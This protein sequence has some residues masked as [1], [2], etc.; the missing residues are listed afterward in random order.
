[1]HFL[2]RWNCSVPSFDQWQPL[3]SD[4][5]QLNKVKGRFNVISAACLPVRF[6]LLSSGDLVS[7]FL[8]RCAHEAPCVQASMAHEP[9][10][11]D[12]AYT[13]ANE[14]LDEPS[15]EVPRLSHRQRRANWILN[16]RR[17]RFE[18][19]E[20]RRASRAVE[21]GSAIIGSTSRQEQQDQQAEIGDDRDEQAISPVIKSSD[22]QDG[23]CCTL[24]CPKRVGCLTYSICNNDTVHLMSRCSPWLC[25]SICRALAWVTVLKLRKTWNTWN[26]SLQKNNGRPMLHNGLM[27]PKSPSCHHGAEISSLQEAIQGKMFQSGSLTGHLTIFCSRYC[28]HQAILICPGLCIG[29]LLQKHRCRWCKTNKCVRCRRVCPMQFGY[30][31]KADIIIF[32]LHYHLALPTSPGTLIGPHLQIPPKMSTSSLG[33]HS[34][35][36]KCKLLDLIHLTCHHQ[37]YRMS[38][39]Q[40]TETQMHHFGFMMGAFTSIYLNHKRHPAGLIFPGGRAGLPLQKHR[41]GLWEKIIKLKRPHHHRHC[42]R[43]LGMATGWVMV[44]FG[45]PTEAITIISNLHHHLTLLIH[46]GLHIGPG[47]ETM[48]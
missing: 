29:P 32:L 15:L 21:Q 16:C 18:Q 5:W 31:I 25:S 27:E 35:H 30:L 14:I 24:P 23:N 42:V 6:H 47:P 39:Q 3:W 2:K 45:Y 1:M 8:W 19:Q 12:T 40:N 36:H 7:A 9:A 46:S 26:R 17:R 22:V 37:I 44:Q 20:A 11:G 38:P 48:V 33:K 10:E 28:H 13:A 34:E 41:A 43:S 4:S